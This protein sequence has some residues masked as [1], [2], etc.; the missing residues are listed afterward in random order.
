MLYG[1]NQGL[2]SEVKM[3]SDYFNNVIVFYK[4]DNTN[5][6]EEVIKCYAGQKRP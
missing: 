1:E 4:R 2:I 6:H 5:S 3:S